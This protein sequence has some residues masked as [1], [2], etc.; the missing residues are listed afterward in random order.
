MPAASHN[1]DDLAP[2]PFSLGQ[3]RLAVE[4]RTGRR[5]AL[6]PAPLAGAMLIS[7]RDTDLIIYDQAADPDQH[8]QL[9]GHEIAHLLLG[10]Q[11]HERP[12]PV[13]HLDPAAVAETITFHGYSQVNEREADDF[14]R[15]LLS[16]ASNATTAGALRPPG[17]ADGP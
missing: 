17:H 12:S 11:P 1:V 5:L 2:Q 13:T 16:A 6:E 15:S 3:F 14:A 10:H 7:T 4:Q 8:L 9:I